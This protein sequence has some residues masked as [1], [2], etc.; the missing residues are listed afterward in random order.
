MKQYIADWIA[1]YLRTKGIERVFVYPGGTIAPLV[2]A[3]IDKGI[4]IDV[5]K[6]EQG[7][8]YAALA[9]ARI[10]GKAQV[11]MVTSGPG[12]TN[13]MSPLADAYYDS[14]PLLL[15]TG[16][17]G[18]ID[19]TTRKNVRQRGFQETPTVDIVKPLSKYATCL[20]SVESVF[21]NFPKAF[22]LSM[23][24]RMG[25]SVIDF[26]MDIQRTEINKIID[27]P[28]ELYDD[29]PLL[30]LD[31][32]SLQEIIHAGE[33]AKRPVILLGQ[34]ALSCGEFEIYESIAEKLNALVVTSFL[35]IGSYN[36]NS[37]RCMGYI[38]HTGNQ[39][40]NHAVNECDFLLVLG[41]RLDI[42]QTGTVVEKFASNA[43]IAWVD[44]DVNELENPRVNV[45]WKIHLD[46]VQFCNNFV[47]I[48][49]IND[50]Y[51]AT[52]QK[53]LLDLKFQRNEDRPN[54]NSI[55]IQPRT[56][57][58]Q[59]ERIMKNDNTVV[60]TGV[61]CHQHWAARHLSYNPKKH[62]YLSS[63][64]HGTMGYDLPSSIGAAMACPE[65]TV[66]CVVGDGSL[67]MNI[68]ELASLY[69]RQLNVK[70]LVLN[71]SRLGIVSQFQLI[72]WGDDPTTGD[73]VSPNFS[74]IAHGFG[75]SSARVD[76][77]NNLPEQ[78]DWFWKRTGPVLLEVMIDPDSDVTPML[79]AGQNMGEMWKGRSI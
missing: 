57:L 62:S 37:T 53:K 73:F 34:G 35:G 71:N 76:S 55:Y 18:T 9:Y 36:T 69:D 45:K 15:I 6:S 33:R 54:D 8:G 64:G 20:L 75:I 56:V 14:T 2:N 40:A 63:G 42:R 32:D 29:V 19:L 41:A 77:V 31:L 49:N 59:I 47:D 39:A 3:L 44:I 25:P 10:T 74:D 51:D 72:T 61:G 30:Q 21:T 27:A 4:L 66:L 22:N 13:I 24:G 78:V 16:Q 17:I 79:L 23:K 12:V 58:D 60:V 28:S 46:I 1:V 7:A 43:D 11:V 70:I 5:F 52:W 38:G 68:Q 65:K 48:L 50:D 26:P 67:L